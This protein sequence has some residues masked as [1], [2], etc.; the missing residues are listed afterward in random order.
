MGEVQPVQ[1]T[2]SSD[3][4]V[5]LTGRIVTETVRTLNWGIELT[6]QRSLTCP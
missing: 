3:E 1:E 2:I 4:N 6:M 5:C